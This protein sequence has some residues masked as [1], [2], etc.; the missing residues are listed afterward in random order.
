MRSVIRVFLRQERRAAKR[1]TRLAV[2]GPAHLDQA[3][4][5][6]ATTLSRDIASL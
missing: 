6:A 3:S 1:R 5:E 2:V 4:A